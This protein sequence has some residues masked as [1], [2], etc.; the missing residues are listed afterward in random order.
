MIKRVATCLSALIVLFFAVPALSASVSLVPESLTVQEGSQFTVELQI[1]AGDAPGSQ[2]GAIGGMIYVDFDPAL[3]TYDGFAINSPATL[4]QATPPN[5]N[6]VVPGRVAVWF[7]DAHSVSTIGLFTFTVIG[8]APDVV[9]FDI[10]DQDDFFGTF[11]NTVPSEQSFVPTFNDATVTIAP[12]PVPAA[13][14]LMASA[15]GLLGFRAR[16]R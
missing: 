16:R 6:S 12:I 4:P 10:K 13:A 9:T 7:E 1:S 2:P 8:S 5:P 11:V 3:V 14:W 15:L